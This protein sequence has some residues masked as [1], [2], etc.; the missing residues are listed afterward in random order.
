MGSGPTGPA[1]WGCIMRAGK[2]TLVCIYGS[3]IHPLGQTVTFVGTRPLDEHFRSRN[4]V[5]FVLPLAFEYSVFS[6]H[7]V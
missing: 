2:P 5:S 7:D 3:R 1:W 4:S 6:T